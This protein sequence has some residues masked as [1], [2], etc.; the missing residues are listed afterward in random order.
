M[1]DTF[2]I[3]FVDDL[4]KVSPD[5]N[6]LLNHPTILFKRAEKNNLRI[7][8]TMSDFA[9]KRLNFLGH[10]LSLE[11][12]MPDPQKITS[13]KS[14]EPPKNI[15]QLQASFGFINFYTKFANNYSKVVFPLVELLNKE[16]KYE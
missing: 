12:L 16:Q 10:F 3:Q 13:I 14:F 4:A 7:N 5:F 6:T 15:K 9:Q 11:G 8:F 1:I 2:V